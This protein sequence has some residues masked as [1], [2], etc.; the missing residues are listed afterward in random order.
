MAETGPSD[1]TRLRMR[2]RPALDQ[3]LWGR[4]PLRESTPVVSGC[5][6]ALC[7]STYFLCFSHIFPVP[8]ATC[9]DATGEF[10]INSVFCE[11]DML[12]SAEQ[13]F[14][15]SFL[16][17]AL[18]DPTR[19]PGAE[20]WRQNTLLRTGSGTE[21]WSE[22]GARAGPAPISPWGMLGSPLLLAVR[23]LGWWWGTLSGSRRDVFL[24]PV[25][26]RV[27]RS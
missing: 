7:F 4:T 8:L 9:L 13:R 15:V 5:V 14:V 10:L 22:L 6:G 16:K 24:G 12:E 25:G 17:S 1:Q 2:E 23:L 27:L 11:T 19:V 21:P 3:R 18:W 20:R 26:L